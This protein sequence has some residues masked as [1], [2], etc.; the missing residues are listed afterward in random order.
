M[1]VSVL[2]ENLPY[3]VSNQIVKI[4]LLNIN[5]TLFIICSNKSFFLL[6]NLY[7]VNKKNINLSLKIIVFIK[8]IIC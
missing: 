5:I 3:K 4:T 6:Y 1:I 7:Y 2:I 8:T